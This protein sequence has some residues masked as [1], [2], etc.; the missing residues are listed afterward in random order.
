MRYI[1]NETLDYM[2]RTREHWIR[3]DY[4]DYLNCKTI[5][6]MPEKIGYT[7]YK[8][9]IIIP[10]RN[11]GEWIEKCL[12]SIKSQIYQ[13][14]EV[15]FVDDMSTDN[16]IEIAQEFKRKG[17]PI[18][19]VELKQR[20]FNGGARNEGYLHLSGNVD[21]VWYVDSDDWL[22]DND[23][24][25]KINI[26]LVG[27]PD[28]LFVGLGT[29][30]QGINASYYI[31][32]YKDKY[33]AIKGWSGSSGKV[34]KKDL[35]IKCL[36]PEGTLKEDRTQHYKVCIEMESYRCLSEVVYIWNRN[37]T[38]SVTTE[39]NIKWKSDTIRNW[40]D[41][42]EMYETYKGKDIRIDEILL[43]RVENC[44]NEVMN[45]EDSQQ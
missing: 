11:Y 22:I 5:K 36:Y 16:S 23:V 28:V 41:S 13:N 10:N 20:R 27:E 14:Y 18:R 31:P 4:E 33:E 21:Y 29:D 24:L 44:K 40:A 32:N 45:N 42:V 2:L 19:I 8:I 38:K 7:N 25:G 1:N 37:N 15:I 34:I 3:K 9:G 35:A 30:I 12:N 6:P 17:M 26:N 39:R 43:A